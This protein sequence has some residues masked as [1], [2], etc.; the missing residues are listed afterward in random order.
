MIPSSTCESAQ[1]AEVPAQSSSVR[2]TSHEAER[3][4][5]QDSRKSELA[6]EST[7]VS[8]AIMRQFI[9][10][11]QCLSCYRFRDIQWRPVR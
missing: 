8:G 6:L 4:G 2:E 11:P 9:P 7:Q 3:S 5:G 10:R 1:N